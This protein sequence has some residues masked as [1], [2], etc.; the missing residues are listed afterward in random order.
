MRL[1][2]FYGQYILQS[3]DTAREKLTSKSR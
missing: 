3:I 1:A 2:D